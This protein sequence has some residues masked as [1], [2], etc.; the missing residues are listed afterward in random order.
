MSSKK[1]S[2][3]IFGQMRSLPLEVSYD[4]VGAW[5]TD[6]SPKPSKFNNW[7]PLFLTKLFPGS[8]N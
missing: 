2:N 1:S 8:W 5:V 7:L 3:K 6:F 4:Q